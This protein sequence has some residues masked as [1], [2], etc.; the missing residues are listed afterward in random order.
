MNILGLA[1]F[2]GS[3]DT[4][5]AIVCDGRLVAAAEEERFTRVKHQGGVP[6]RAIEYCLDAAGLT[7]AEVDR[8]AFADKPFRTGRDSSMAEIDHA[9]LRKLRAAGK[10]RFRAYVHHAL[11]HSVL[12]AG[13]PL[14]CNFAMEPHVANSFAQLR[15]RYAQLP[16]VTFYEH[17]LAHAA[18]AYFT[19]GMERAA[20]ATIDGRGGPFATVTW[21][22]EGPYI[23]RLRAEP[24]TNS[25]GYF[26]EHAT[27]YL[28]LGDYAEGKTM[29][30]AAYGDSDC[31]ARPMN[32][33]FR[34]EDAWYSYQFR[35]APE[36]LGFA[37]RN[38]ANI[39]QSPYT[40]F[41]AACQSL[42]QKAVGN[43]ARSAVREAEARNLCLGGGIGFNCSSNGALLAGGVAD[44]V[45][46]F[47]ASGDAGLSVGAALLCARDHDEL[48]REPLRHAFWGPKFT[49]AEIEA[50]LKREPAV[51]Y[52]RAADIAFEIAAELA[53]GKIVGWFQG[54]MEFGPRAL[55]NRSILADSRSTAI[56]DRVNRKKGR[57]HW[58]P[59]APS[60]LAEH[61]SQWFDLPGPSEF[62]L[63]AAGV[64]PDKRKHISGV[65][66]ADGSA[67]PQSVRRE[68]NPRF[69]D[70]IAAFGHRTGV[71]ILL[72]TSLNA[73]GE[74]IVCTP[75]D[76]IRSFLAM[77]LDVLALGDFI[78]RRRNR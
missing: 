30:L 20:I 74:P 58:R 57:E 48:V 26:Y 66:H 43:V 17:H 21:R 15:T 9:L 75:E 62:M 68:Q 49:D 29:A 24:W 53:A 10:I 61:A 71:P 67:R 59:L 7:M 3:H 65:V 36:K 33:I 25:I 72:N 31:L 55:G 28:G 69:Y 27:K 5:A 37:A 1:D 19:S 23:R 6:F 60:V 35:P 63:V 2:A 12:A 54:R 40:D 8:I 13:V 45:A 46:I 42:L 44:A 18:A 70:A 73:A 50:A 52:R 4:S 56:R 14:D 32:R 64:R 78:A 22:A 11:L 77:D 76:A 41:A 51:R 38:G 16:P 39:L 47:P 34:V